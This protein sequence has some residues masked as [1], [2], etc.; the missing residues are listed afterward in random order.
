MF[1]SGFV[2]AR[3]GHGTD[4]KRCEKATYAGDILIAF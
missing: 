1:I 3:M 2:P 4:E